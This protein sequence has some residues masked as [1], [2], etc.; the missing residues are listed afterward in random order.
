MTQAS[1]FAPLWPL[2]EQTT[3]LNHGSFGA[4][5]TSVLDAQRQFRERMEANPVKFLRRDLEPLLDE[6]RREVGAFLGADP[7]RLAFL[8]NATSGV[9]TVLNSLRLQPGDELLTTDHAYN[10]CRIALEAAARRAGASVVVAPVPFPLAG[11]DEVVEAVIARTTA[12]TKLALLDHVTS[13]TGLI[14]P[15]QRLVREL[16]Q[17]GVDTLVDGAHA[18]GMLP[19][20]LAALGAAYY[21]GNGH[22][23]LC[24]PKGVAFLH[25][26][27][28]R[29]KEIRPLVLSHGATS[30]RT[31][32]SRFHLEFD[33]TGTADPSAWLSLPVAIRFLGSLLPGGWPQIMARNHALATEAR[34]LVCARLGVGPPCPDDMLGALAALLLPAGGRTPAAEPFAHDPWQAVLFERFKIEVLM[35]GW[36]SPPRRLLRFSAHLYNSL[37]QYASLAEAVIQAPLLSTSIL[38]P[39]A[40]R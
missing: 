26:R 13:L 35:T 32:R 1:P 15:I 25:V 36:P 12:R 38:D 9:T 14:F 39:I 29:Q 19:I 10:A 27:E 20:N 5:P 31:D 21:V 23:W 17:R 18:P 40:G 6:A 33:W 16:D 28:D 8:G 3:F 22:K 30:T 7:R 34:S 11:P 37:P 24:A 2:D 4:C